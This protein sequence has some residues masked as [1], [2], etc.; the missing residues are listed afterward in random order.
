MTNY[1]AA[2]A[3]GVALLAMATSQILPKQGNSVPAQEYH[4]AAAR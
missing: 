2:T 4:V 1:L 3:F